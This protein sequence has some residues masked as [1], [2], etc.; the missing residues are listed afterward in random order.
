[1]YNVVNLKNLG[2]GDY[3]FKIKNLNKTINIT[4]HKGQ[5]WENGSFILKRNCLFENT[6]GSKLIKISNVHIEENK[7][8]TSDVKIML[9]DFNADTRVHAIACQF[10]NKCDESLVIFIRFL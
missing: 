1:M 2:V 8:G 6:L 7:A 4:I 5:F 3:I 9:Q 10:L